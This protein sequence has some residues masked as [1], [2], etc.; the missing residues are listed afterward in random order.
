[1][2]VLC[3]VEVLDRISRAESEYQKGQ[4]TAVSS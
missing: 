3:C 2:D 1:M 4:R